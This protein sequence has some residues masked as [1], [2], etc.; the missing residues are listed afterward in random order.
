MCDPH[1]YHIPRTELQQWQVR[2]FILDKKAWYR[3]NTWSCR[4]PCPSVIGQSPYSLPVWKEGYWISAISASPVVSFQHRSAIM[5][6]LWYRYTRI[7][8][9]LWE[10]CFPSYSYKII[11]II[12]WKVVVPS[13]YPQLLQV[14]VALEPSC[15]QAVGQFTEM[16]L[17]APQGFPQVLLLGCRGGATYSF[18]PL[19]QCLNNPGFP[20]SHL[21]SVMISLKSHWVPWR[22]PQTA[23]CKFY[24]WSC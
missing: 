6:M 3:S 2:N 12:V 9:Y 13:V 7:N 21:T 19:P 20:H 18:I 17:V 5:A 10:I 8:L 4:K 23:L 16:S 15:L 11:L 14:W 1:H 22:C 24:S